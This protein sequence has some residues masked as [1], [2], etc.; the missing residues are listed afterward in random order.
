MKSNNIIIVLF[1]SIFMILSCLGTVSAE[2]FTQTATSKD[3]QDFIDNT[4]IQDNI[5]NLQAGNYSLKELN[6]TRNLTIQSSNDNAVNI[7]GDGKSTLFNVKAQGVTI[8]NLNIIDYCMAI[9]STADKL[10]VVNNKI[11]YTNILYNTTGVIINNNGNS[12]E[13]NMINTTK[14][15]VVLNIESTGYIENNNIKNNTIMSWLSHAIY[16]NTNGNVENLHIVDN[17]LKST[18]NSVIVISSENIANFDFI[19][20]V[21][22]SDS[23][24]RVMIDLKFKYNVENIEISSNDISSDWPVTGITLTSI[25]PSENSNIKNIDVKN[26]II[27]TTAS[28]IV[29]SPTN[30]VENFNLTNNDLYLVS[31]NG[32]YVSNFNV[33][34]N[35]FTGSGIYIPTTKGSNNFAGID[36]L[37]VENNKF[38]NPSGNSI[39]INPEDLNVHDDNRKYNNILI[40]NNTGDTG[41]ALLFIRMVNGGDFNNLT[42]TNN[43]INGRLMYNIRSTV[44]GLYS[45]NGLYIENNSAKEI[46][47]NIPYNVSDIQVSNNT[48]DGDLSFTI[49]GNIDNTKVSIRNNTVS[50]DIVVSGSMDNTEVSIINNIVSRNIVVSGSQDN[51]KVYIQYNRYNGNSPSVSGNSSTTEVILTPNTK[52][53]SSKITAPPN[54]ELTDDVDYEKQYDIDVSDPNYESVIYIDGVTLDSLT[55]TINPDREAHITIINSNI[56]SLTIKDYSNQSYINITNNNITSKLVLNFTSNEPNVYLA[57]NNIYPNGAFLGF[58]GVVNCKNITFK[59]NNI[60]GTKGIVINYNGT[61]TVRN[62]NI[63]NN[64]INVSEKGI[65]TTHSRTTAFTTTYKHEA[66]F[67]NLIIS[68]NIINSGEQGILFAQYLNAQGIA[69]ANSYSTCSYNN[70]IITNN[71]I[72]SLTNGI[73]YHGYTTQIYNITNNNIENNIIYTGQNGVIFTGGSLNGFNLLNNDI[74]VMTGKGIDIT[75]IGELSNININY[76]SIVSNG[77]LLSFNKAPTNPNIDYNW[78]GHNNKTTITSKFVNTINMNYYYKVFLDETGVDSKVIGNSVL[79]YVTLNDDSTYGVDRLPDFYVSINNNG[80]IEDVL[81]KGGEIE[82]LSSGPYTIKYNNGESDQILPLGNVGSSYS[83]RTDIETISFTGKPGSTIT[84]YAILKNANGK[85]LLGKNINFKIG[86]YTRTI[87]TDSNGKASFDYVAPGD[88]GYFT[89]EITFDGD[90]DHD[91]SAISTSLTVSEN[92]QSSSSLSDNDRLKQ[93][94]NKAYLEGGILDLT[95]LEFKDINII[96]DR[97][98]TIIGGTIV[99]SLNEPIFTI[100]GSNIVLDGM[101]LS[102]PKGVAIDIKDGVSKID[103]KN[104]NIHDSRVGIVMENSNNVNVINN[105]FTK[106]RD[107]I[108]LNT[109]SDNV[110]IKENIISGHG[111]QGTPGEG[112]W[113]NGITLNTIMDNVIITQNSISNVYLGLYFADGVGYG[114]LYLDKNIYSNAIFNTGF[115][116]DILLE[117][118]LMPLL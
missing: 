101:D 45:L 73:Q 81:A 111:S 16:S 67:D 11:T 39:N 105:Y 37:T 107:A 109:G 99:S 90:N 79:H 47:L 5:I 114:D 55:I 51:S 82:I 56:T 71:N 98:I 53:D 63:S 70:I 15:S 1:I 103:I 24:S 83:I 60:T 104:S 100:I 3:V 54:F 38:N 14:D 28:S 10:T 27:K 95:G 43:N 96:L 66:I 22:R 115:S 35:N 58:A 118:L 19:N 72:S 48:V 13:N 17:Y 112:T 59:N 75:A 116:F 65:V 6:I 42:V 76:N 2:D 62:L 68:N 86:E 44:N 30:K 31:L 49:Y 7:K 113:G 12:I 20:N 108:V 88:E 64:I 69:S 8:K 102:N 41:L 52:F 106:V 9:N 89:I 61:V 92:A 25:D 21:V 57:E 50:K 26:N 87:S 93:M 91:K 40:N 117:I 78:W 32:A 110:L 36:N 18:S 85:S 97:P 33:S 34:R 84:I 4:S 74:K 29:L 46:F 80:K 23:V 94:I 77:Q